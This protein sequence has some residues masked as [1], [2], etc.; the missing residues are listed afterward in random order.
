MAWKCPRPTQKEFPQPRQVPVHIL[1]NQ[2]VR[3]HLESSWFQGD[4]GTL[5][6]VLWK[7]V[8]MVAGLKGADFLEKLVE[9]YLETLEKK[10]EWTKI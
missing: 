9:L 5:E 8:K 7:V 10:R 1:C 4:K 3:P 2:Y 6:R